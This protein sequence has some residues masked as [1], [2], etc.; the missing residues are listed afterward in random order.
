[1]PAIKPE[2]KILPPLRWKCVNCGWSGEQG[3]M[4]TGPAPSYRNQCPGC[5]GVGC[6]EKMDDVAKEAK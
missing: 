6:W 5:K 3:Q 2:K 4:E 1:V